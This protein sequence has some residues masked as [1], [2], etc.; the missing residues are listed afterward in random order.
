MKMIRG[1]SKRLALLDT[2]LH[3]S[4][5][6]RFDEKFEA[7]Q[8]TWRFVEPKLSSRF[9]Q[10]AK[11]KCFTNLFV[12]LALRIIGGGA[13]KLGHEASKTFRITGGE[14]NVMRSLYAYVNTRDP[15]PCS[16]PDAVQLSDDL[17]GRG[18]DQHLLIGSEMELIYRI[19]PHTSAGLYQ[20]K[21]VLLRGKN[22]LG[23]VMQQI[24]SWRRI[25][26]DWVTAKLD[27]S[28]IPHLIWG[29]GTRG[30]LVHMDEIED[31]IEARKPL[32]RTISVAEPI[33]HYLYFPLYHILS[34]VLRA[35]LNDN[36][37]TIMIG[38]KKKSEDWLNLCKLM[39]AYDYVLCL[40]WSNFDAS[41][42]G[43]LLEHAW[44]ILECAV[45]NNVMDSCGQRV[46]NYLHN[47]KLFFYNNFI[48]SIYVIRNAVVTTLRGVP[49]GSLLTSIVGS[50]VNYTL[51]QSVLDKVK[52][53]ITNIA[54]RVYGDDSVVCFNTSQR[55][56]LIY[57]D[58]IRDIAENAKKKFG[59]KINE[60]K[61]RICMGKR[62][63]VGYRQPVYGEPAHVL[64]QG[65]SDLRPMDYKYYSK[66]LIKMDYSKGLT[67]RFEYAFTNHPD[68]LM[69][70]MDYLGRPI[71]SVLHSMIRLVNT[72]MPVMTASDA[73][74]RIESCVYDNCFN[75][76]VRNYG[77]HL[78]N[79]LDLIISKRDVLWHPMGIDVKAYRYVGIG[80]RDDDDVLEER[81]REL[82][83]LKLYYR[84]ET[85][86][87]DFMED[88]RTKYK[89]M[90][91]EE[92]FQK[93]TGWND[94]AIENE[95]N[96][97]PSQV[98][99]TPGSHAPDAINEYRPK[100]LYVLKMLSY[101]DRT[102]GDLVDNNCE[103][104]YSLCDYDHILMVVLSYIK[105]YFKS[106]YSIWDLKDLPRNLLVELNNTWYTDVLMEACNDTINYQQ[107][108]TF[109]EP[110]Y[111]SG[112]YKRMDGDS[113]LAVIAKR[114]ILMA[115]LW[116][117][118]GVRTLESVM[119]E[120]FSAGV[121]DRAMEECPELFQESNPFGLVHSMCK[122]VNELIEYRNIEEMYDILLHVGWM[123]IRKALIGRGCEFTDYTT[124]FHGQL[125]YLL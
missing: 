119:K 81:A 125:L 106:E 67:H 36:T 18:M 50:V 79:A 3:Y 38:V 1:K 48:K 99:K 53:N 103:A 68:F 13:D 97:K 60:K 75:I 61:T 86:K 91:Y 29:V 80:E 21:G 15:E 74:M 5:Y 115:Q 69:S 14:V 101:R 88:E 82:D 57:N 96:P 34:T 108:Y 7:K 100:G 16:L 71:N 24:D 62:T 87:I 54:I 44:K 26:V 12:R 30:K 17:F 118:T 123:E 20:T 122:M 117:T 58:L 64:L 27:P 105:G 90:A 109:V 89:L 32:C 121:Q 2:A 66:P 113:K 110:Q 112:K 70:Y 120:F 72:E 11:A 46:K 45:L 56:P 22:R 76:N 104:F 39:E 93:L 84:E 42:P 95:R 59:M 28:N 92:H 8:G 31:K 83:D 4:N 77:F 35:K 9:P 49:S 55:E 47:C 85:R 111:F 98:R 65:T 25:H 124:N 114:A 73:K 51:I 37:A 10:V 41:V 116:P 78:I 23:A 33:E 94:M 52:F 107:T 19:N 63:R 40:D 43:F 102:M 6:V